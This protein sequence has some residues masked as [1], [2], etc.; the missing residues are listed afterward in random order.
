VIDF[1]TDFSLKKKVEYRLKRILSG[2]RM[3]CVPP[4]MYAGRFLQFV[5]EM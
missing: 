2:H 3:S 5:K 4:P 1:L